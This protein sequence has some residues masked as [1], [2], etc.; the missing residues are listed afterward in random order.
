MTKT[1]RIFS[2]FLTFVFALSL[3]TGM[4]VPSSAAEK[5]PYQQ[6]WDPWG[7]VYY[8]GW[9]FGDTGCG[10]MST[11]NAINYATGV[12]ID[13]IEMANWAHSIGGYTG[14]DGS[15]NAILWPNLE[16]A[17][18]KKYGFT[19]PN[20]GTWGGAGS[21]EL[22]NHCANGGVAV[23]NIYGHF[24][25]LVNYNPATGRYLVYDSYAGVNG[26]PTTV[27]GD[28]LTVA[29]LS[30][31]YYYMN[32]FWYC[33]ISGARDFRSTIDDP[34]VDKTVS[35]Q[36]M[37]VRGWAIGPEPMKE[38]SCSID[39]TEMGTIP[40]IFR[41]DV[42]NAYG[43]YEEPNNGFDGYVDISM[44][45]N[46]T[47]TLK[48][49]ALDAKGQKHDVGSRTFTVNNPSLTMA[50]PEENS[51]VYN[52]VT[53]SGTVAAGESSVLEI[54]AS[55]D[56]MPVALSVTGN[57]FTGQMDTQSLQAG[58]H[59][60][61]V[62]MSLADGTSYRRQRSFVT[63]EQKAVSFASEQTL[64]SGYPIKDND[65]FVRSIDNDLNIPTPV[66]ENEYWNLKTDKHVGFMTNPTDFATPYT[67]SFDLSHVDMGTAWTDGIY[68]SV[69]A[70]EDDFA[71]WPE[72]VWFEFSETGVGVRLNS[73]T[74]FTVESSNFNN[75]KGH[76]RDLYKANFAGEEKV[77]IDIVN[78]DSEQLLKVN[79]EDAILIKSTDGNKIVTGSTIGIYTFENNAQK[80]QTSFTVKEL[81][82]D[83]RH[84]TMYA[85]G[86]VAEARLYNYTVA[87]GE[88]PTA[89][90]LGDGV[91]VSTKNNVITASI[92]MG[93]RAENLHFEKPMYIREMK[94]DGKPVQNA[95]YTFDDNRTHGIEIDGVVYRLEVENVQISSNEFGK[96]F[97][98]TL[99]G[100]KTTMP[101]GWK[102]MTGSIE[103]NGEYITIQDNSSHP[104]L[105]TTVQASAPHVFTADIQNITNIEGPGTNATFWGLRCSDNTNWATTYHGIWL[106]L[107]RDT[108][109]IATRGD[110]NDGFCPV[111]L[112]DVNFMEDFHTVRAYDTGDKILVSVLASDGAYVDIYEFSGI[113]NG[114]TNVAYKNLVTGESGNFTTDGGGVATTHKGF[115]AIWRHADA[116]GLTSVVHVKNASLDTHVAENPRTQPE[117]NEA[118]LV[119][120]VS[121]F[122][123]AESFTVGELVY[124]NTE[125][126][127]GMYYPLEITLKP[128]YSKE[129]T[130]FASTLNIAANVKVE[131]SPLGE[132]L[133]VS[134]PESTVTGRYLVTVKEQEQ[135][136]NN[137]LRVAYNQAI[138][139]PV[140]S[141]AEAN[142]TLMNRQAETRE[143]ALFTAFYDKD[144]RLI[145]VKSEKQVLAS[146]E[147]QN[148][149]VS[150]ELPENTASYAL[151]SFE[152]GTASPNGDACH[153][154]CK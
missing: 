139:N 47:H 128:G 11:V 126:Y 149:N 48:I 127:K 70:Y 113:A 28:W 98:F 74:D 1:K 66:I 145:S 102:V 141:L 15:F 95:L 133:I 10:I 50:Q 88:C 147:K 120:A 75:E 138:Y 109:W 154:E 39:G 34:P 23:V 115:Y 72:S 104:C 146:G 59:I 153:V 85:C 130:T 123:A 83:G 108:I 91:S 71:D 9:S 148:V 33:L 92:G 89:L 144:G 21:A 35:G 67:V 4:I 121:G 54:T 117:F 152:N 97:G 94:I 100:N 53:I 30:G 131:E 150:L 134:S 111:T 136:D 7:S 45:D 27:N 81:M 106:K 103:S 58:K 105:Y 63:T 110:V 107:N 22:M 82:A 112:S 129:E 79:G 118:V 37:N 116:D 57:S 29:D 137:P 64:L 96:N 49:T 56:G 61:E 12:F 84:A 25:A 36:T 122:S 69:A 142:V 46:G 14:T 119:D 6:Y 78:R 52:A 60:A 93:A 80:L 55:V 140:L 18:G 41:G 40:F 101:A 51:T 125:D 38:I 5:R 44:L 42:D 65:D 2:I 24:M 3:M 132:F 17:F 31:N 86:N 16:A 143:N 62:R 87:K 135:K 43:Y 99:F 151:L 26:N 73:A 68:A 77:H 114:G 90:T 19:V 20:T 124:S 32:V 76:M 8:D 13:P